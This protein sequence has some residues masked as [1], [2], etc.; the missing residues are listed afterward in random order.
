M[1]DWKDRFSEQLKW[2]K[3]LRE[4][5]YNKIELKPQQKLL[6]IGCGTGAL[7]KEIGQLFQVEITGIDINNERIEI[8]RKRLKSENISALLH[9]MDILS[10]SFEDE[11]FDFI[12]SNYLFL[13]IKDLDKCFDE[14]Y[15]ILKPNGILLIFAEPDYGGLIEH[16]KTGLKKALISNLKKAGA[17]PEVGRKLNH[18]FY[19]KFKISEQFCASI[20]WISN[21]NQ[22]NLFKELEFFQNIL[23]NEDWDSNRLGQAIKIRKYFLFVPIFSFLLTKITR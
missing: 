4:H 10:N 16:P 21:N 12:T 15:R 23:K 22:S 8:A 11:T 13:W 6:E 9:I 5:I 20:P 1:I 7:L 2:T 19:N 3:D 14:I 18:Y 17:D